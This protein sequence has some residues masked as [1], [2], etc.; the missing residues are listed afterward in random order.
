MLTSLTVLYVAVPIPTSRKAAGTQQPIA[1]PILRWRPD[2]VSGT[3]ICRESFPFAAEIPV[4]LFQENDTP[5]MPL[6][7][8]AISVSS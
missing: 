5:G 3:P 1:R 2:F 7:L 6:R 8:R 4:A